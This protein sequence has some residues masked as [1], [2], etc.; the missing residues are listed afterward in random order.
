[1]VSVK[2]QV[3]VQQKMSNETTQSRLNRIE[4]KLDKMGEVLISIARFEEKMDSY[5]EYRTNSW[6][7][8]NKFSEKLDTIEKKVD[9]NQ[10]TVRAIN[11][12]F[13]VAIVAAAGAISTHMWM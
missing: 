4:G 13:W 8:M 5:N 3:K 10:Y 9:N 12:L 2:P 1:M 7:R 6:E 11:K